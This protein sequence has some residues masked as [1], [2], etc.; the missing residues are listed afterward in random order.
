MYSNKEID[1]FVKAVVTIDE[2]MES[3]EKGGNSIGSSW[4][5][6]ASTWQELVEEETPWNHGP[7]MYMSKYDGHVVKNELELVQRMYPN[8]NSWDKGTILYK[9]SAVIA[10]KTLAA[11]REHWKLVFTL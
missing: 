4:S 1:E 8:L 7:M 5:F 9:L 6:L 10:N 2:K 3:K 11:A